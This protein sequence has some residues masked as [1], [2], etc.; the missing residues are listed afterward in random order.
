[1]HL[2]MTGPPLTKAFLSACQLPFT[3]AFLPGSRGAFLGLGAADVVL[4]PEGADDALEDAAAPAPGPD[5][6]AAA[7]AASFFFRFARFF[8]CRRDNTAAPASAATAVG[9]TP[10]AALV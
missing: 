4:S 3:S 8:S 2:V 1:M 7:A 6:A 10:A 9:L 5:A